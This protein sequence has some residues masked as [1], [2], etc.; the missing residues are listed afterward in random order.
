VRNPYDAA[1]EAVSLWREAEGQ[2]EMQKRW[3]AV[4]T[5]IAA[6]SAQVEKEMAQPPN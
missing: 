2:V 3:A 6:I 4:S 1:Y 5:A